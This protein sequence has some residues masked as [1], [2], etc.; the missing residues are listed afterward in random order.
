MLSLLVIFVTGFVSVF[1]LGF[2]SRNV[3]HGNYALAAG[4]SVFVGLSQAS[5]WSHITKPGQGVA[6]ALVYA[7]AGAMAITSS[8]Y[9]HERYVK[10]GKA[11]PDGTGPSQSEVPTARQRDS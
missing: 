10:N 11:K 1:A 9:V 8:M 2:Q 5:L 3:N 7:V 6:G 4:T